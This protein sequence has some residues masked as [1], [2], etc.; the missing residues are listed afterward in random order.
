MIKKIGI[1]FL[2]IFV[3]SSIIFITHNMEIEKSKKILL[4]PCTKIEGVIE[5][6][7]FNICSIRVKEKEYTIDLRKVQIF[8]QKEKKIAP[9]DLKEGIVVLVGY[10]SILET[11]PAELCALWVKIC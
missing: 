1:C 3:I 2:S 5:K 4:Q 10:T 8:D 9:E 7:E 11:S 6:K